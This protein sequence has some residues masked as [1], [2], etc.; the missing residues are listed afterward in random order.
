MVANSVLSLP[1]YLLLIYWE[2]ESSRIIHYLDGPMH[3]LLLPSLLLA[4][5]LAFAS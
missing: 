5:L 3:P 4:I 2:S 1:Y